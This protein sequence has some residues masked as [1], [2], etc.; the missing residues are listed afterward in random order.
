MQNDEGVKASIPGVGS[1]EGRGPIVLTL[2]LIVVAVG[3]IVYVERE[4]IK[5]HDDGTKERAGMILTALKTNSAEVS[6]L[7]QQMAEVGYIMTL[8]DDQRR[9]LNLAMPD[10]LR[11]K[12]RR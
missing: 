10:S 6:N 5:T 3:A 9:A 2:L 7:A 12:V 11:Q 4:S 1:I 8:T